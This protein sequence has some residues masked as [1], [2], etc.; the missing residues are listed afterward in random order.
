MQGTQNIQKLMQQA[1]GRV[2]SA[3]QTAS[4]RT[5][6]DFGYLM[7]QAKVESSFRPD[8]KAST[9]SAT[10]LFQFTEGTWLDMMRKYG[11]KHGLGGYASQITDS[12]GVANMGAKRS[13]LALRQDPAVSSLM[14]A[15]FAAE[16]RDS[17][18]QQLNR[19][20]E[21]LNG[22]DLY[23]AHFLGAS[24]A[25]QFLE[26]AQKTPYATAAEI[27]PQ[28]ARSNRSVFYD[29]KGRA[30]TVGE[31]YA[32]F[33][34]KFNGAPTGAAPQTLL[35]VAPSKADD[36]FTRFFT[37]T[38]GAKAP[39]PIAVAQAY[40]ANPVLINELSQP[41]DGWARFARAMHNQQNRYNA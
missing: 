21:S 24:G 5:G 14:A 33:A 23:M 11:E 38:T 12:N 6:V 3:I 15:E 10:G 41:E 4:A 34:Q 2:T 27:L 37:R 20:A 22:T 31:V 19:P 8:V 16:N 32:N 25:G 26:A 7:Q 18:A 9:S 39:I 29:D 13:I 40:I 1:G 28:A 35:A 17:L 36:P 30:K